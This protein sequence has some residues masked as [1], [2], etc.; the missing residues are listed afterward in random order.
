MLTRVYGTAFFSDKDLEEYLERLER[1]RAQRPPPARP[2]AR[3]VQLLRRLARGGLLAPGRDRGVQRAGRAQPRDGPRARLRRGQD[4]ADLRQLAVEDLGPL[5]QVPREHVRHRV[6]GPADGDQA[7][8]LPRP[9]PALLAAAPLLPGPAGALLGAG[10]AAP[11]RAE[12]HA[13][14][15][16]A[17]PPLRPGRRA[18]SSAPRTR[19]RRRWR[20]CWSSPSRPTT[21][22]ASTCGSSSRPGREQRIGSDEL[23]D[24]QR[25]GADAGAGRPRPRVRPQRGRRR[26]LRPEDRHAHDRLA[27]ALLAARHLP[28]RLQLPRAVRPHLHRRRQRRA[29]AGDD[30]PGADGLLR[31]LHRDPARAPRRRAAAR[32]WRR[33]RRS[34][35]RSP[36]ATSSTAPRFGDASAPRDCGPSSTTAPSRSAARSA[37]PSCARSRTCSSSATARRRRRGGGA[38]APR[39]RRRLDVARRLHRASV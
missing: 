25:G 5:G 7:D 31:A 20:A 30:P 34:C 4:A 33:C 12:R 8:E 26:L 27:R 18:T 1:A 15:A 28:A 16:A 21:C 9:L 35:C 29:P 36:T 32:G 13:A 14:R 19:S 10:P 37:T 3:A 17:R 23:W 38:R 11:P 6:R 2:A 39:R 24:Q 22:S